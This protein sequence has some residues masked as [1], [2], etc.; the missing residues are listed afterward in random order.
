MSYFGLSQAQYKCRVGGHTTAKLMIRLGKEKKADNCKV[1]AATD[2]PGDAATDQ[3]GDTATHTQTRMNISS[4]RLT[5]NIRLP[6]N[7][8]TTPESSQRPSWR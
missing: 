3:P 4:T 8:I 5:P 1:K 2:Q 6:A 7:S